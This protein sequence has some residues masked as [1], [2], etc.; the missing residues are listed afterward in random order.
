MARSLSLALLHLPEGRMPASNPGGRGPPG[1][2]P[3]GLSDP[4][5]EISTIGPGGLNGEAGRKPTRSC[6]RPT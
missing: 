2:G 1:D 3:R 6:G 5:A 4:R